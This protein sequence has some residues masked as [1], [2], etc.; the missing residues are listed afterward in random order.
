[1][2]AWPSTQR[3]LHEINVPAQEPV[4]P[5]PP[6]PVAPPPPPVTPLPPPVVP[7][8]PPVIPPPPPVAPL[9]PPVVV[10]STQ[11]PR[12]Q[13]S[14]PEHARQLKPL[15]P[16]ASRLFP[17]WQAPVASQQPE[18]QVLTSQVVGA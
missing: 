8:P 6:P 13:V 17:A 3:P 12:L 5:P 11:A 2:S 1:V 16:H 14:A 18:A 4:T 10:S 9:P 7:L 15:E